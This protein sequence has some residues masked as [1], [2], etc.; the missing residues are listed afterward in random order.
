MNKFS[1]ISIVIA[2]LVITMSV[3]ARECTKKICTDDQ[4]LQST[5]E[6]SETENFE[7]SVVCKDL[8]MKGHEWI[9]YYKC[10]ISNV[11]KQRYGLH[12][13]ISRKCQESDG[14]SII[15]TYYDEIKKWTG[16]CSN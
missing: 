8:R 3:S 14:N 11:G 7:N 12:V 10:G 13:I 9:P 16:E 4:I 1:I 6:E 15:N 5:L 2:G